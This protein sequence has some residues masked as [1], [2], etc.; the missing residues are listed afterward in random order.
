VTIE[1]SKFADLK[2]RGGVEGVAIVD[3]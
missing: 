1:I 3:A 2:P